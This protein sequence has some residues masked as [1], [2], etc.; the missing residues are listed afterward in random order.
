VIAHPELGVL[1][2]E[3]KGGGL[4]Y[5]PATRTWS[6]SG[7]SGT[8]RVDDPFVQAKGEMHSLMRILEAQEGWERWRPSL[9]FAVAFPDGRYDVAA[10]PGAPA[11][12][13]IDRDDLPRLDVRIPTILRYW[14]RPGRRFGE[15]GMR[16]LAFALGFRVEIRTPLRLRFDEEDRRIVELTQDQ[17]WVLS[18]VANRRRAAVTGPAGSGKTLLALQVAKRLA[19]KGSRTLLTCF[20]K[21]LGDHLRDQA[22]STPGLVVEHFHQLCVDLAGEAGIDLPEPSLE[23]GSRTF[24][25]DLPEAL[26]EAAERLGPR[27]DAIVVDEAQDFKGWWWPALLALHRDPDDGPL[28]VF[29]DASQN[30]YGGALPIA[31]QD[32]IGPIAHNLRN[33]KEI[34]EFVSVFYDGDEKPASRGP[35]GR[36]VE[37]LG[38][39]DDEALVR[40][41][42]TVLRNL[43]EEEHVPLEDIALLTPSGTGKS[44][45]R[46]HEAIG[47]YRLSEVVGSDTLLATSVHAFKGLERPVVILAELGDKHEEDLRRYLYVGGSRARNHLIVLATEP[48]ARELRRLA[49]VTGP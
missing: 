48:V 25:H 27:F 8:H 36:P 13:A 32:R 39:E 26:A 20:N 34:A 7:H 1:A 45:L 15:A 47:G 37:V 12:V 6:Q 3:V 44:R 2:L 40:L 38:Y 5:D 49:G 4:R 22:A 33:T 17:A 42:A 43:V 21:R 31:E 46:S 16:A 11:E 41:T 30:L 24:E 23:P 29:A 35:A 10:H 28:Y 18:F 14:S 19:T 9:G